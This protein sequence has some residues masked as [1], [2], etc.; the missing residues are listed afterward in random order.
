M[1]VLGGAAGFSCCQRGFY[2][3]SPLQLFV[4]LKLLC[5]NSRRT[6]GYHLLI[7]RAI[8]PVEV[9]YHCQIQ[10]KLQ[11]WQGQTK[12]PLRSDLKTKPLPCMGLQNTWPKGG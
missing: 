11:N 8:K 10:K 6:A 4:I 2:W 12:W 9:S 5:Y 3:C 7:I 1:S